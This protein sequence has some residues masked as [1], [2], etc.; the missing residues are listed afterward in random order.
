M[1]A[2]PLLALFPL[3]LIAQNPIPAGSYKASSLGNALE[4]RIG[5]NNT[6]EL[7]G[8]SGNYTLKDKKIEFSSDASSFLVEK[9][10]NNSPQLQI[11]FKI[12]TGLF[13][14]PHFLYVGYEN[15][16]GEVEYVCVHNKIT[17]LENVEKTKDS[18]GV[19]YYVLESF[20]VPRTENLYLVNAHSVAFNNKSKEVIIEKYPIGKTTNGVEVEFLGEVS[21]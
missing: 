20:E 11:T 2:L 18:N 7:V 21:L 3:S 15:N 13:G 4:L 10:Q 17:S 14:D 12:G 9:K 19:G 16:K 8:A 6:Y 5:N 1:K